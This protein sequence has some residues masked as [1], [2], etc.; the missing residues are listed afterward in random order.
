MAMAEI[1]VLGGGIFGLSVAYSLQKRGAKT[2]LIEKYRIGAGASGG[3]V[4]ALA[5]HTPDNWN[6]KKQFQFESLIAMKSFWAEVDGLSGIDSGYGQIGR[7]VALETA[8]E[9]ELAQE[10]VISAVEFWKGHADWQVVAAE[11]FKGWVPAAKT[12]FLSFDSLSARMSPRNACDSLAAAF[13]AIGGE[14]VLGRSTADADLQVHCTGYEGLKELTAELG[15]GL[16]SGVKGQGLLLD[17]DAGDVPQMFVGGIH[18][19]PHASGKL[20]VGSTSEIEWVDASSTDSLL[21]DLLKRAISILPA[22]ADAKVLQRWAGVRPRGR[23]RAPMLGRHPNRAGVFIANGG[24]KIGFGVALK[25]GE[26]MADLVLN[27]SA[28]IPVGF[29]VEANLA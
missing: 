4:G 5:P 2:R 6:D 13:Q 18:F 21:D 8:R 29:S 14:I 15:T 16:G 19:I 20:A 12:G 24:F 3:V 28:E 10:R 7:L 25:A 26:V 17:Y 22:L 11:R 23:R 9:L 1:D 27:G